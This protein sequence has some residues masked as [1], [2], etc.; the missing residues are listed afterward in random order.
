M[1]SISEE[2]IIVSGQFLSVFRV[3]TVAAFNAA[4]FTAVFLVAAEIW[5]KT[6]EDEVN[7]KST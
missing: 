3:L 1:N 5:K 6:E 2:L 4:I 7:M